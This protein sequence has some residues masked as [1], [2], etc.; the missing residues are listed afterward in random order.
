[1]PSRI[2]LLGAFAPRR[3]EGMIAGAAMAV[4]ARLDCLRNER[5]VLGIAG[6]LVA[7]VAVTRR[8]TE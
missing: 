3:L 8:V 7:D 6:F 2:V 1:M 4:A 5:R